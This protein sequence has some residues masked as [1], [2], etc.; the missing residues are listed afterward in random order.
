MDQRKFE[1]AGEALRKVDLIRWN[2]LGSKL[3]ETKREDDPTDQ[4]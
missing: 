1:F 4:P 3:K 2:M